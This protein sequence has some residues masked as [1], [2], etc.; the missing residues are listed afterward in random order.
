[1]FGIFGLLN[2]NLTNFGKNLETF[3]TLSNIKKKG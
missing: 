1:M 3:I 2:A